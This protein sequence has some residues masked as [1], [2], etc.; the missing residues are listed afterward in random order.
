[1]FT[2]TDEIVAITEAASRVADES[3]GRLKFEE[4]YTILEQMDSAEN[5]PFEG[6]DPKV[7]EFLR[8]L[9]GEIAI[10][11]AILYIAAGTD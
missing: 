7:V 2:A 6:P 4:F 8:I 3:E 11:G 1:M 9:E 10:I 5:I